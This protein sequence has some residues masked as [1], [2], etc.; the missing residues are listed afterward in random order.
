MMKSS[1][2]Q[3]MLAIGAALLTLWACSPEPAAPPV[4]KKGD[5]ANVRPKPG[6][7]VRS[8]ARET[9]PKPIAAKAR[10]CGWLHNPTP[11]NWW[12]IDRDGQWVLGSQGSEQAPGMDEMPDMS[13]AEW[14]E[15]NGSY[16]YG[17]ACMDIVAD[18]ATGQVLR[19]SGAAA[20][21]LAQCRR[22]KALPDPRE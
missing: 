18:P 16:G 15:T 9:A 7:K 4:A 11:A 3:R 5:S 10:R 17:C 22:D 14:V 21:P 6:P 19:V 12:L 13:A 8:E 20:K 2:L 1:K